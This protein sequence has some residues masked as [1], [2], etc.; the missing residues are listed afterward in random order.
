MGAL[1][2]T[3]K[4]LWFCSGQ[5]STVSGG[6]KSHF[7]EKSNNPMPIP[8]R[9]AVRN[10]APVR[11]CFIAQKFCTSW[12]GLVTLGPVR[13]N[14][15]GFGFAGHRRKLWQRW[16]DVGWATFGLLQWYLWCRPHWVG[17]GY[18]VVYGR[19]PGKTKTFLFNLRGQQIS[20]W[21]LW[22]C[23]KGPY[24]PYEYF[25]STSYRIWFY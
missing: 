24:G 11:K 18:V 3:R 15:G 6:R 12:T 10:G 14:M 13:F 9:E 7:L 17:T 4:K 16:R 20:F 19:L 5:R 21:R 23:P 22:G 8:P 25:P 2:L 1:F